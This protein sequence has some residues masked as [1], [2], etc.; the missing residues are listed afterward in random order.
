MAFDYTSRDFD[1]IRAD[2]LAR[3][4]TKLPSWNTRD[5][6]DFGVMLVELWAYMGDVLHY[7][8][9]RAAGEAFLETAT[10]RESV[11]AIANLLDYV[12]NERTAA[13]AVLELTLG[14]TS[15]VPQVELPRGTVFIAPA[16]AFDDAV[17][18]TLDSDTTVFK[19][20]TTPAVQVTEGTLITETLT[21]SSA[22]SPGMRFTLPSLSVVPS[23]I[24]IFVAEGEVVDGVAS[25]VEYSYV[26][27][28]LSSAYDARVFSTVTNAKDEVKVVFG[29]GVNGRVPTLRARIRAEYRTSV[30]Q[31][32]NIREGRITA[33]RSP[34]NSLT[35]ASSTA[36][37]GGKNPETV[38]SMKASIPRSFR[39]NDRA[40]TVTDFEDISLRFPG[41][42]KS[43]AALKETPDVGDLATVKVYAVPFIPDY[44]E[45]SDYG[46]LETSVSLTSLGTDGEYIDAELETYLE[47]R[48]VLGT[49]VDLHA[50]VD[51]E[52][53]HIKI[54]T[55]A[56]R[57][58]Y[59]RFDV[60]TRVIQALTNLFVFD[61]VG[62]GQTIRIGDLYRTVLSVTG[63]DYV[64]IDG[65]Y[66]GNYNPI[67]GDNY[68]GGAGISPP[69]YLLADATTTVGKLPRLNTDP[70]TGINI[71]T[72]TGG[73]TGS[74]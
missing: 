1:T 19:N 49:G 45:I 13:R 56:V 17:F 6:S 22:G 43:S 30:G 52:Y 51:Y 53:V 39:T 40:V 32:G 34:I 7:Y 68:D 9:D 21:N 15:P 5:Q 54:N 61:A 36:A 29:N 66:I 64:D 4:A 73:I 71:V 55:L 2:L 23:S 11:L 70:T 16:S 28:L 60:Q 74:N 69:G 24:R 62:F 27:T 37:F 63:V 26:P 18:F 33:M 42:A 47:D 65:V 20:Q 46:A 35:I 59:I 58:G 31:K 3:A 50:T 72:T 25:D 12:P 8:V 14:T 44:T 41:V 10:Q 67:T 48:A 38:E 57:S